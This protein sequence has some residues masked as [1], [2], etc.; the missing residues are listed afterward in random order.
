[1]IEFHPVT[2][3]IGA[4]VSGIDIGKP[5]DAEQV[6]TIWQGLL[7]H[8]V[9]FFRDQNITD[10]EHQAFAENFGSLN[11]PPMNTSATATHIPHHPAPP[12]PSRHPC[13]SPNTFLT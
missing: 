12:P 4:E 3:N 13:H 11:M 10:E 1:M 5:L 2:R 6:A 9:L 8:M 7:D